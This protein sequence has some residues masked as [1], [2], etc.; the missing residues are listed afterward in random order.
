VT[1][2]TVVFEPE[3]GLLA[4][5]GRSFAL[6]LEMDF[7]AR[8]IV[9]DNTARGIRP[10]SWARVLREYGDFAPM[11]ELIRA[12]DVSGMPP[13]KGW[14]SQQVLKLTVGQ[15][16]ATDR[17][18]TL[19]AKNHLIRTAGR[20]E[21][22]AEDGRAFANFHTYESHP[23][24]PSLERVLRYVGLDP[25]ESVTRFTATATPFMLYTEFT[26]ELLAD[27]E[28][29]SG[30]R[31]GEEFIR[32]KLT[33]YFLY[34]SWL[35]ARGHALEVLYDPSGI[36]CPAIWPKGGNTA[37]VER[38]LASVTAQNPA[39]FSVHRTALARMDREATRLLSE[40]W[41]SRQLFSSRREVRSFI[42]AYRV[43]YVYTMA[44]K[45]LRDRGLSA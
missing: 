34:S 40:F 25:S 41:L 1:L 43:V 9:I 32:A 21:F 4:L 37:G 18:L 38:A 7:V 27:L 30:R 31:F 45:K 22:E 11:V 15:L 33:E 28:E 29:R 35:V 44:I 5:Q 3:V 13:A 26:R 20:A 39:M 2:V 14:S 6:Y 16:V 17:Y 8:I 42:R 12:R 36:P 10:R 23:L 24:R 19:D